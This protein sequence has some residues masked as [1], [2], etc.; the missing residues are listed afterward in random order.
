MA[1][2]RR[3]GSTKSSKLAGLGD[4]KGAK[5]AAAKPTEIPLLSGER[6]EIRVPS[7]EQ[8]ISEQQPLLLGSEDGGGRRR[9]RGG[10]GGGGVLGDGDAFGAGSSR[11][12]NGKLITSTLI[13]SYMC[14]SGILNA[15]QVFQSSGIGP[16]TILYIISGVCHAHT[17]RI[18]SQ[19]VARAEERE[20]SAFY[21]FFSHGQ[22]VRGANQLLC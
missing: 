14:G 3:Y 6:R 22:R 9:G 21:R 4:N 18:F 13:L 8:P 17:L 1:G 11:R 10:G 12:D 19:G 2:Q 5:L 16:A 7:E 20:S 15:P